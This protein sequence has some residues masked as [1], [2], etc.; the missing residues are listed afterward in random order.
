MSEEQLII[1]VLGKPFPSL[2]LTAYAALQGAFLEHINHLNSLRQLTIPPFLP[3]EVRTQQDLSRC[4]ALII[5]GGESTTISL[6]AE[7]EG[8]LDPLREFVKTRHPTW[9]TCAG[10]ILLSE[11]TTNP[12]KNGQSLIGGLPIRSTRNYFG[13]QIASFE[14]QLTITPL[15]ETFP[16]IFIRAPIVEEIYEANG[17]AGEGEKVEVF[18]KVTVH[19]EM[20]EKDVIVAVRKGPIFGTAFHPELTKDNRLH[21]WWIKDVVIPSWQQ[22]KLQHKKQ[23]S[24]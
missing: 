24:L 1:G 6:V 12:K 23:K 4:H 16:A 10:L 13:S 15:K 5:P 7:R 8:L 19:S 20:E 18:S 3:I 17:D 21:E 9:G 11:R 2:W 14:T 22:S